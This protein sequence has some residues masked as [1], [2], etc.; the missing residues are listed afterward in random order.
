VGV[1]SPMEPIPHF[2]RFQADSPLV[3]QAWEATAAAHR[4]QVRELDGAPFVVH[5]A[6]VAALL[7]QCGCDEEVVAAGLLHDAVEKDGVS[8]VAVRAAFGQRIAELV[9]AL[10]DDPA[11]AEFAPRKARLLRSLAGAADDALVILAADKVA[12]TRELRGALARGAVAAGALADRREHYL[13][14]LRLVERRLPEHPLC[15][16][17]R[18]ELRW[19]TLACQRALALGARTVAAPGLLAA[20]A[21]SSA[22]VS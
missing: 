15:A 7:Q 22:R 12:K 13:A 11:I 17:L 3:R 4:G 10:T 18:L 1:F 20:V 2:A 6:E 5:A 9:D 19:L 21:P 16:V 8:A 14:S